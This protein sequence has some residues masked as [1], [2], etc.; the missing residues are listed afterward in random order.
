MFINFFHLTNPLLQ[1]EV[2]CTIITPLIKELL[3]FLFKQNLKRYEVTKPY[4]QRHIIFKFRKHNKRQ[5][6]KSKLI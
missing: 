4:Q 6:E 1:T 3:W 5:I 2:Y